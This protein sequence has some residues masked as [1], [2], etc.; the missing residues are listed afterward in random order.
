MGMKWRVIRE[1]IVH[2]MCKPVFWFFVVICFCTLVFTKQMMHDFSVLKVLLILLAEIVATGAV[3]AGVY[4][5]RKKGYSI[6]KQFLLIVIAIGALFITVMPPGQAPDEGGHFMR[7]YGVADGK[8]VADVLDENSRSVGSN[9]PNETTF[10]LAYGGAAG[11][12]NTY[13]W[14]WEELFRSPS[15]ETHPEGYNTLAVYNFVCYIP[16]AL[17]ILV[18][19]ILGLSVLAMGYL[20]KIFNFAMFVFL[21]YWAIKLIPKYKSAL[22]FVA[23]LPIT[24]QEATSIAPDAMAIALGIFTISYAL[25]LSSDK[26]IKITRKQIA[27]MMVSGVVLSLC[28]IVYL[29]MVLLYLIVPREKFGSKKQKWLITGGVVA[30]AAIFNLAWLATSFGFITETNKGVNASEQVAGVLKNPI[31]YMMV[32][33][34]TITTYAIDWT[35]GMVGTGIGMTGAG[36]PGIYYLITMPIFVLI[37]AQ[38]NEKLELSVFQKSVFGAVLVMVFGLILTSLYT[39]WTPLNKIIIEG[40]QGRYFLPILLIVPILCARTKNI[41]NAKYPEIV[42][43][44]TI[45]YYSVLTNLLVVTSVFISNL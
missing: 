43:E 25:Y 16:Q 14:A 1:K 22:M 7:A 37:V 36:L 6:E 40:V 35:L 26:V 28:K 4:F 2:L 19:K 20:A 24:M 29:P 5:M 13:E 12:R 18:G 45:I 31:N 21:I 23:L 17:G 39:Q 42:R 33:M 9:I 30:L 8:L 15:G 34:R 3:M 11:E 32:V 27:I 38:R 10:I 41:R 44:P